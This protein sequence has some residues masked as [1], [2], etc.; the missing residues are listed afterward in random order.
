ML[1]NPARLLVRARA[2]GRA[3][4]AFN[5]YNLETLQGVA[6][7]AARAGSPLLLQASPRTVEFAGAAY[8][9]AMARAAARHWQI[10]VA[11]HLDHARD[12]DLVEECL[13]AGFTSVM[14]DG[15][16]LPLQENIANTRQVVE[17]AAR[18]G[19]AVE[20][21][22]GQVGGGGLSP[23]DE[24]Y[25]DPQEA[26]EFARATGVDMLAVAVGTA[27]GLYRGEPHLDFGRLAE[28]AREVPLPLVLH[29]GSGVPAPAIRQAI[30]LGIAKVNIATE[31]KLPFTRTLVQELVH[32]ADRSPE[33]SDP[34][35]YMAAAREAVEKIAAVKVA[36]CWI[37]TT[38]KECCYDSQ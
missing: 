3:L 29:G 31:L 1:I 16:R 33:E 7:A 2:Q 18:Y 5:I 14:Y 17:L 10:P 24:Q 22:L 9:V 30:A 34:R 27:H 13:R 15:S 28:I 8:L 12:F 4:A 26:R 21:E 6:A 35:R 36:M 20:G 23:D 37:Q 38:A 25:T 11:L 32:L 19:A